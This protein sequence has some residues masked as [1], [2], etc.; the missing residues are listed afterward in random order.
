MPVARLRLWVLAATAAV[1]FNMYLDRACLSQVSAGIKQDL[2]LTTEQ[3]NWALSAFFWSYAI[4]Q[5][6][7]AALGKRYGYRLMLTVYL[8]GWSWYTGVS[9]LAWGLA[10]LASARVLVGLFEAGAYPT[11]AA[12]VRGWFPLVLRGRASSAVAIGGRLGLLLSMLFT[13][14]LADAVGWRSTLLGFGVLGLIVAV[15]FWIVARDSPALHP[16]SVDTKDSSPEFQP[17]TAA[18]V[19]PLR[20]LVASRTLWLASLNQFAINVGWAFLITKM[21]EFFDSFSDVSPGERGR[22]SALPVVFGIVGMLC[23]GWVTDRL[24]RGFGVRTGRRVPLGLMPAVAAVAYLLCAAAENKWAAAVLIGV[25]SLATDLANPAYWA[26][27]QDVGRRHAA[28]AL[29]WGNMFGQFGAALSPILLGE[30]Q[31]V[32]GWPAMFVAGAVAFAVG[33]AAGFMMDASRPIDGERRD[34]TEE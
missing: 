27:A 32:F 5:I 13:P 7:A 28:A 30:V 26:F 6:P 11:A 1:A 21:P 3:W 19:L 12:L 2:G 10:G 22:V 25:M 14:V 29:G 17:S 23:G 15:V 16:W 24:S 18:D 4:G 34:T 8:V 9:G 31:I 33:S 20:A